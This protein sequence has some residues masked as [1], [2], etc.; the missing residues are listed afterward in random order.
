MSE[1]FDVVVLGAGPGGEVAAD[2]LRAG[3]LRVALVERE[4]IGGECAYWACIPSKTLLRP[5]E[6]REEADRA[7]G[8]D[9]P[10]LGFADAAAYRDVMIRG[11][12]DSRQ[13]RGYEEQGVAVV[14]GAGRIAGPGRVDVAGRSLRT[15]RI[16]VATG[17]DQRIPPIDGLREAGFWTN[18]EATTLS[19]VPSTVVVLGGGASG[20]ESAQMLRR[21]GA[22]VT[23]V[24]SG[25]RLLPRED[26]RVGELVAE[27]LRA[28]GI[29]V[30]VGA[31]ASAVTRQDGRRTVRLDDG[32]EVEGEQLL[33]A[34][35]RAPRVDGLGLESVGIEPRPRGIAVDERCRAAE[36]VWAIGDVTGAMPFTHVA[37]YQARVVAADILGEP[38]R[39][40]L[41]S[42]PRVVFCDPEVG[43]VGLGEAQARAQ[44]LRLAAA[45][46]RLPEVI[47]R[48][49]T[50]E[51]DPRGELALLADRD[52]EVLV[53]AWAVGAQAS[54]WIHYAALAIKTEA[55]LAVL[56]DSVA[57]FPSFTEGYL[58]AL[59][60]LEPVP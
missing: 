10:A 40:D 53:G 34:T 4:L 43:A 28:D 16:V 58:Y 2:R 23:L 7:A 59:D 60:R 27:A 20:I 45:R 32:S 3:G 41:R 55:P 25:D 37:K 13:V 38:A 21:Y 56:R 36:G 6:A 52:R 9:R 14:K 26:P 1:T 17:S 42:V 11:L 30:R 51:Q 24:Q 44:G 39:V 57:Q 22:E 8:L 19:E 49:W 33:V 29:D 35:G 50:Y 31:R 46:V 47:A 5:P 12:D 54:E 15:E 48:P 18:R